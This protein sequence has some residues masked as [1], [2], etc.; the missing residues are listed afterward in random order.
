MNIDPT[1]PQDRVEPSSR[2]RIRRLPERGAYDRSTIDGILDE[3][4]N[5]HVGFVV[6]GQPYVIPTIHA[7]DGDHLYLHGSS[8][9]RMLRT[10]TGGVPVCVTV[11]I[12]DGLV[13]ARSAFHHSMNYRSV[14]VLG[15]G[16]QVV[17]PGEELHALEVISEHMTPGRWAEV[18]PPND[19]ELG[20]T[21]VLRIELEEASAKIRSG[22]PN[23]DEEDLGWP[24][25]S[26]LLPVRLV[27]EAPRRGGDVPSAIELPDYLR[28]HRL[29][30]DGRG[31]DWMSPA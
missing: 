7:R 17:D 25:W 29:R 19:R 8:A 26:G 30:A 13:L 31:R 9:S 5:C 3:A 2:T 22:G 10:L 20:Q 11:T 18:R 21:R 12:Q 15:T 14:V 27:A 6:D 16:V 24:V 4:L 23:D 28:H 1:K